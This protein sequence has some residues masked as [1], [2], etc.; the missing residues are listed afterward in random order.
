MLVAHRCPHSAVAHPPHQLS[1]C[2]DRFSGKLWGELVNLRR[3][4]VDL[5]NGKVTVTKTLT[6]HAKVLGR[7][8]P[9]SQVY[10]LADAVPGPSG[11][12]HRYARR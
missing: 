12:T 10:A 5:V 11:I 6:E 8:P 1:G 7:S 2:C 9:V 4:D 3:I